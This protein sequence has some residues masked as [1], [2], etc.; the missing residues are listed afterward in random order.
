MSDDD[1]SIEKLRKQSILDSMLRFL[2]IGSLAFFVPRIKELENDTF[3]IIFFILLMIGAVVFSIQFVRDLKAYERYLHFFN[4]KFLGLHSQI[5]I[6]KKYQKDIQK[7]I[8]SFNFITD[9]KEM[10]I[11]E[12]N[13]ISLKM[14]EMI[15]DY[16]YILIAMGSILEFL[17][18]KYCRVNNLQPVDYRSPDG[19][20]IK[21]NRKRFV[22]YI[23]SAINNNLFY[24]KKKW[25]LVQTYLRDFRNYIHINKECNEEEIDKNWYKSMKPIFDSI[26]ENFK[27]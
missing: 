3:L 23:Q 25:K 21:A 19:N 16:K 18:I 6:Y 12:R 10:K 26:F 24:Q 14:F 1:N 20:L 7:D 13:L 9:R 8:S 22:N 11:L 15:Q 17:L 27:L 4:E 2:F 5:F